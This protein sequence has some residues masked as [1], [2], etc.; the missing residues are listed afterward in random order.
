MFM[1]HDGSSSVW[2][3]CVQYTQ[4]ANSRLC[5]YVASFTSICKTS[6]AI[7]AGNNRTGNRNKLPAN[8]RHSGKLMQLMQWSDIDHTCTTGKISTENHMQSPLAVA[9]TEI[10]LK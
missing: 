9:T 5:F 1:E 7:V 8:I 2:M 6:G 10:Q 4:I 3:L